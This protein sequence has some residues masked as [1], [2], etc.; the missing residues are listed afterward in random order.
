MRAWYPFGKRYNKLAIESQTRAEIYSYKKLILD[1]KGLEKEENGLRSEL[2]IVEKKIENQE[3]ELKEA[4]KEHDDKIAD[5]VKEKGHFTAEVTKSNITL[6]TIYEDLGKMLDKER[7][8]NNDL[9]VIYID[10]DRAR[11]RIKDLRSQLQ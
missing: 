5:L 3:R 6:K 9:S 7:P 1:L 2:D 10:I 4:E 11:E 8:D